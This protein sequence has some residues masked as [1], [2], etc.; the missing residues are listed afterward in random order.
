[1]IRISSFTYQ[2]WFL[3]SSDG[4]SLNSNL[5]NIL[6]AKLYNNPFTIND[7]D[8]HVRQN[9]QTGWSYCSFSWSQ[10]HA[11]ETPFKIIKILTKTVQYPKTHRIKKSNLPHMGLQSRRVQQAMGKSQ[12]PWRLRNLR[13]TQKIT[14]SH[15][16][17]HV[18][19]RKSLQSHCWL[20]TYRS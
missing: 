7:W 4:Q 10:L 20:G 5:N 12:T 17:S 13:W 2:N 6:S 8:H 9:H 18:W 19:F 1:M 16:Q 15:D 11:A 14:R 3:F